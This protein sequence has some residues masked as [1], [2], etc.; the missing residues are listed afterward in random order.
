MPTYSHSFAAL[1]A[2]ARI[3]GMVAAAAMTMSACKDSNIPYFTAP[4]SVPASPAGIEN[5]VGGLFAASRNDIASVPFGVLFAVATGYS[6]DGADFTN[7]EPRTITDPLGVS[8]TPSSYTGEW[9]VEYRNITQARQILAAIPSVSPAYSAAQAQALTGVVETMEAFNYMLLLEAHDTLGIAIVTATDPATPPAAYCMK[10]GWQYVVA[11]LDSANDSLAAAGAIPVPVKLPP[12]F[13]GVSSSAGPSTTLGTFASL[14]RAWAAKANLELAYAIARTP[15][16]GVDAPTPGSAGTPDAA[17]LTTAAA[18][19]AASAL[20]NPAALTP[21]SPGGFTPDAHTVTLDFSAQSGD[22]ANGVSQNLGTFYQ[23]NDFVADVDTA[24]DL[25]WKAK[26]QLNT[27]AKQDPTYNIVASNYQYAMYPSSSSPIPI[28]R[29][30]EMIFWAAQIEM[31]MGNYPQALSLVNLV[32][33]TV[34]GLTAFPGSVAGSYT[35]MRD[36]LMKEQRISTTFEPGADRTIAIR[37]YGLAAVADTTWLH[38]DPAVT[39]G[40][41]HTTVMPLELGELNGRGGT[42]TTTCP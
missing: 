2:R 16:N 25:R 19:L 3:A 33:T 23:L 38:E 34:G 17:A 27:N 21:N 8:P 36:A 1:R 9:D 32:R 10:D 14:N 30:E 41:S 7:T 4:T 5:V 28:I 11:L 35:S 6:R 15:T 42:F 24:H 37:M 31:G 12:G 20:Y 22:L 40:D 26:F 18:D 13:A 39:T 29:E